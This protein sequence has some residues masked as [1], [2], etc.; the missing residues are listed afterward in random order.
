MLDLKDTAVFKYKAAKHRYIFL[1]GIWFWRSK[2][3]T[4]CKRKFCSVRTL[5]SNVTLPYLSHIIG[6]TNCS[7]QNRGYCK[8]PMLLMV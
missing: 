4:N 8:N 2:C 1:R 7:L 3:N 6:V 5:F